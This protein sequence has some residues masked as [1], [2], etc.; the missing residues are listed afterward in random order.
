MKV[1]LAGPMRGYPELNFPAFAKAAAYLRAH[2]HEVFSP[3]ENDIDK[4]YVGKPIEE[5]K[6]D[7]I[8]DDLTYIA[9]E[10]EAIALL[11]GWKESKGVTVEVALANFLGLVIWELVEEPIT[12]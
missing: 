1:Y 6:R 2:G 10:A 3:A 7:C 9:R 4:G 12:G 8:M 5:I 11:T